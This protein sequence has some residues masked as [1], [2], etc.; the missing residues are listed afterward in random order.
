MQVKNIETKAKGAYIISISG[1][2]E[3]KISIRKMW[4]NLVSRHNK[5]RGS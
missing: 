4:H 5:P 3:D 1:I 2:E